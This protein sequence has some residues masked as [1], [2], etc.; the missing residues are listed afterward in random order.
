[1]SSRLVP[2]MV[3]YKFSILGICEVFDLSKIFYSFCVYA[4]KKFD[5]LKLIMGLEIICNSLN[6]SENLSRYFTI[7]FSGISPSSYPNH[8]WFK[9]YDRKVTLPLLTVLVIT[10]SLA[11][12]NFKWVR[13]KFH[14]Q[15]TE[16]RKTT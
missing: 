10:S 8:L 7:F 13:P 15:H 6:I 5:C 2:H 9:R 3:R 14:R 11:E 1:M 4:F 16:T 12:V